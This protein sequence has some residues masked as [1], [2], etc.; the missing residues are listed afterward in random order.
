MGYLYEN[1]TA[2]RFQHLCQTLLLETY[3]ELQCFPV[4][5]KD[6]GRDGVDLASKTI[7]QVKFRRND[8]DESADWMIRA[9]KGELPKIQRLVARGATKYVMVTNARPTAHEDVGRIDRVQEWLDDNVSIP[10]VCLW[11]DDLDRR[12]DKASTG[13]KLRYSELLTLEDGLDV[14]LL[15]LAQPRH[16][17]QED[18]LRFF[19]KKQFDLDEE[20]K[21]KQVSL[22]SNLLDLFVDVPVG[23]PRRAV[24]REGKTTS[25][26]VSQYL[27]SKDAV[28]GFEFSS[29]EGADFVDLVVETDE[30]SYR[31][32]DIGAAEFLFDQDAQ[33]H[34]PF[35][36]LEG[37]PG[38]G[39]S[40]LAQYVC[41]VH[42]ARFLADTETLAQIPAEHRASSLR[43]PVKIDLRDFASFL[44]GGSPFP[45]VDVPSDTPRSVEG[46]VSHLINFR[47][48]LSSF[49]ADDVHTFVR[50]APTLFF[51]DGLD[52]VPDLA[53]REGMVQSI[54]DALGRWG[55][56]KADAQVVVTSRP[57]VFGRKPNLA[58]HGFVT[59]SLRDIDQGRIDRYADQWT[60]A[61]GL[62]ESE[63]SAVLQILA[64]KLELAHIRDLTRNPMQLTILLSLIHQ[65]G[66]SLP[67]QRTD[68]YSRYIDTFLTREAD[69]DARVR[70]H[71]S[72]LL[73][74]LG[75]LAW[76]LQTAAESSRAAGSITSADLQELATKYLEDGSHDTRMA[77]ELFGGGLERVFVLVER[78]EGLYEF[79][80]QPIREYFC[81]QYLYST[82]PVGTYRQDEMRGDRAQRFEAIA[83]NPFWLN[84]CR[85]YA[86]SCS[87]GETGTLV[88]SL[89]EAINSRVPGE[90]LHARRV[91]LALLQDW[92]FSATKYAQK[93]LI[94]AIF[95]RPGAFLYFTE[96][97]SAEALRLE[98]DCGRDHLRDRLYNYLLEWPADHRT[99]VLCAIIRHNGGGDLTHRFL[100]AISDLRGR[101]RSNMILRMVRCGAATMSEAEYLQ[102]ALSDDP[103]RRELARRVSEI[104]WYDGRNDKVVTGPVRQLFIELVLEGW[105]PE[106]EAPSNA[107][108]TFAITMANGLMG[109]NRI[110]LRPYFHL[111]PY[112]V[113][114]D[115]ADESFTPPVSEFL[116][117]CYGGDKNKALG[118]FHP[119]RSSL[120][121]EESR[122]VLGES[123]AGCAIA[124]RVAGVRM[125]FA[126]DPRAKLSMFDP[127]VPLFDRA[128]AARLK[129]SG[130]KWWL[131]QL[132]L[133]SNRLEER[134]WAGLVLLWASVENLQ[135]LAR[136]LSEV[137]D[138]WPEDD[139]EATLL[140]LSSITE[141]EET[142]TDRKKLTS[143]DLSAFS[144]RAAVLAAA[145]LHLSA[146]RIT[147]PPE[148]TDPPLSEY[149][150]EAR[151][152][153]EVARLPKWRDAAAVE[154]W[155]A[156][157][158]K[159]RGSTKGRFTRVPVGRIKLSADMRR[160]VIEEPELYPVEFLLPALGAAQS[161][162]SPSEL[163]SRARSEKWEFV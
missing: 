100:E 67:D 12:L 47:S 49:A 83:A 42:R 102:V 134:F 139:F 111:R 19:V 137:V 30:G 61:S 15:Q 129:R 33:S 20:V 104:V 66:H 27:D 136:P 54:G 105:P 6:G 32:L 48:G 82:A 35:L 5:Q 3:P 1:S 28:R 25:D 9:L 148:E 88:L 101:E 130:P 149:L 75:F 58:R 59:L 13:L 127:A 156:A 120:I 40:T 76:Q 94:D 90:S 86:G 110:Q 4:A 107:L 10:A 142:R 153:A 46:F 116:E 21:F 147:W 103:S 146:A 79:E 69:K 138:R 151:L 39:K 17:A 2:D 150:S 78:I 11:R 106:A 74:F 114:L 121:V 36:L 51:F 93:E 70:E 7:L 65:V 34:L 123:W 26:R 91:A 161:D 113:E 154:K 16:Q 140:T 132:E 109:L 118:R 18:A 14:L 31:H 57:S 43:L 85:F 158:M 159:Y 64:L 119:R 122:R 128:R 8:E 63:K 81:A 157:V 44:D 99:G 141:S 41:Q 45:G 97:G 89:K 24:E 152:S 37:A 55:L 144:N 60:E 131:D 53:L 108:Q 56:L 73:E 124:L 71:R 38:Q 143:F 29:N 135:E 145:S 162:L 95:D 126:L 84:V 68:L 117:A 50:N 163:S 80:V 87:R 133:A 160:G 72:T 52:E 115:P 96:D 22:S 77:D 62:N 23:F 92:V 125:S 98:K 155:S 112:T